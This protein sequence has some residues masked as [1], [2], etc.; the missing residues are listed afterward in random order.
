MVRFSEP[1]KES[2]ASA[3]AILGIRGDMI[4]LEVKQNLTYLFSGCE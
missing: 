2:A 3:D 1:G 4:H